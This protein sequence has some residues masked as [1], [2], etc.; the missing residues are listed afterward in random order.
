MIIEYV[1]L[2]PNHFTTDNCPSLIK[3]YLLKYALVS[4]FSLSVLS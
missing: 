1:I 4:Y 2:E 3:V